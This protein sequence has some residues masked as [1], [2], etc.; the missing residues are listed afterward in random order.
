MVHS[1]SSDRDG[2]IPPEV[3]YLLYM[4]AFDTVLAGDATNVVHTLQP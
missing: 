1:S 2:A 4:D 3:D